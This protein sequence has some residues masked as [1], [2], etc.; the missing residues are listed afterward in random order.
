MT[1]A[2]TAMIA[3]LVVLS[4]AARAEDKPAS[5]KE[6]VRAS[7]VRIKV[8]RGRA[9]ELFKATVLRKSDDRLLVLTAAHCLDSRDCGLRVAIRRPDLEPQLFGEVTAVTR[10]PNYRPGPDGLSLGSDNALAVFSLRPANDELARKLHESLEPAEIIEYP[11]VGLGGRA[12]PVLIY[13]QFGKEH[14]VR[15]SNLDNPRWMEW[16]AVYKPIPGDSGSGIFLYLP[17]AEGRPKPYVMG[18]VVDRGDNGGGGSILG[19][20]DAWIGR[21]LEAR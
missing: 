9:V 1:R 20:R 7:Q 14:V 16:G 13:D 3:A 2:L 8:D 15:G 19:R 4:P 12:V 5:I 18:S 10:N 11:P 6:R 17:D 21:A